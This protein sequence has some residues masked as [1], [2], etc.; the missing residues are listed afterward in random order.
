MKRW[1]LVS[2]FAI[3]L[4]LLTGCAALHEKP[5]EWIFQ[6]T[7]RT[8]GG[9]GAADGMHDTWIEFDSRLTGQRTRPHGLWLPAEPRPGVRPQEAPVML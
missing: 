7:D 2:T 5:G 3:T 1:R 9:Y 6:P 8:W 4:A